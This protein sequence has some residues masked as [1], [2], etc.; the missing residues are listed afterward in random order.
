MK[1]LKIVLH[2]SELQMQRDPSNIANINTVRKLHFW[3]NA[4][5]FDSYIHQG[6]VER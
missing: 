3:V 5:F 1:Q 6:K 2:N 4:Q